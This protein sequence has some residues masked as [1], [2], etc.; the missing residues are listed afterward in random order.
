MTS[1]RPTVRRGPVVSR[2]CAPEACTARSVVHARPDHRPVPIVTEMVAAGFPSPALDGREEGFSLD[3]HVIEHPEYTFIVT[4]AGD[5]WRG[6]AFST[7]IGWSWT[8][9]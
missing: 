7:A 8:V 2:D 1:R 9:R 4:V 3:A 6:P 5:P